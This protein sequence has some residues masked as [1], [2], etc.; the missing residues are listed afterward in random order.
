ML[1]KSDGQWYQCGSLVQLVLS[2]LS[3]LS[4][5]DSALKDI[6]C[7]LTLPSRILP[8]SSRVPAHP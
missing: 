7:A 1:Q 5:S 6:T 8:P 3:L 4:E 2:A